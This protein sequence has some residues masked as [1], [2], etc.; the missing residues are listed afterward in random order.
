MFGDN[1][2]IV[3]SSTTV[4]AK[5]HKRYT[6]LLFHR[7]CECVASKMIQFFHIPGS[8]NP[9]D[10]LAMHWAYPQV[11][12]MLKTLL[13]WQGD[14]SLVTHQENEESPEL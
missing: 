6:I 5:L 10:I 13:F 14:T 1:K 8:I 2:S 12:T 9:A 4:H 7:V 3:G 11:W